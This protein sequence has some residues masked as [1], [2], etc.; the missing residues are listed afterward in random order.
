ML[1]AGIALSTYLSTSYP[2]GKSGMTEAEAN[3]LLQAQA[4]NRALSD[5]VHI[6]AALGFFVTLISVG[7]KRRKGSAGKTVTQKPAQ[8]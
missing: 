4:T 5:L 1:A 7:L 8:T 2:V 6:V 3:L